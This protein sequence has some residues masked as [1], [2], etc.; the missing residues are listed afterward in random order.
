MKL[1]FCV[2]VASA[3]TS[4]PL[5]TTSER[6]EILAAP[7]GEGAIVV[8]L[9]T[10]QGCSSCPP[11]DR[12]LTAI[13]AGASDR[14]VIAL[15]FHVDYWNDL[16]W[17]DPFSSSTATERQ[18]MYA[19]ALGRGLF[20][21]QVVVNGRAHV[22]GSRR[23]EVER[24]LAAAKPVPSMSANASIA[25]DVLRIR[26]DAPTGTRAMAAVFEDDL[27]TEVRFGENRGEH[28]RND[29]V[30]RALVPIGADGAR[31]QLDTS[32]RR[33][34]L[35]VVVLAQRDDATIAAATRIA[36]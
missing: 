10:S 30:V 21:P 28:L 15:A 6:D 11:A 13:A 14:P 22:V 25:G 16:G 24:A 23:G 5:A 36:L 9:F 8:E 27:E 3:C 29:R 12:L 17:R 2:F 34:H 26:A 1:L 20:T 35:G 19:R 7:V 32:W 33:D 18:E 4:A 31:V